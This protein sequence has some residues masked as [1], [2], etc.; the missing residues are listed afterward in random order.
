MNE[1]TEQS[2]G[3][4]RMRD[5]KVGGWLVQPRMCRLT[6][7]GTVVRLRP[8]LVDLLSTLASRRGEVALKSE[9]MQEVWPGRYVAE[10]ALARCYRRIGHTRGPGGSW[11]ETGA[12]REAGLQA[13]AEV[14]GFR[15]SGR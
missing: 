2:D 1:L 8:Q 5:F 12:A 15:A 3:C 11:F 4:T 14:A 13:R 10:T 7:N 6:R 9:L